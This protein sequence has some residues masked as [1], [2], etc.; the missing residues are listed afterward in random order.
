MNAVLRQ[1]KGAELDNIAIREVTIT[2]SCR[3]IYGIFLAHI[4]MH[5]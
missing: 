5:I 3:P 4:Y 2:P 1:R